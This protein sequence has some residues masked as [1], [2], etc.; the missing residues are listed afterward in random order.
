[1][2]KFLYLLLLFSFF[3]ELP[4]QGNFWTPIS[5]KEILSQRTNE[6]AYIPESFAAFQLDLTG[7]ATYLLDAP[8]EFSKGKES[9]V[10]HLP[11]PDGRLLAFKVYYSPVMQSELATKY[12]NIRSYKAYSLDDKYVNA[13]FDLGPNGL[14]A[15]IHGLNNIY[16]DPVQQDDIQNYIVYY[17][18]D[19]K[20]DISGYNLTCGLD[21][22]DILEE[23]LKEM[24]LFDSPELPGEKLEFRNTTEE[25]DSV[26]LFTYRLALSCTGEWGSAHGNTVES[27]LADMVTSVNRINQIYENEFSIRLLL[28]N[29]N[30]KLIW[31][32]K[33]TD[34]FP[35]GNVGYELLGINTVVLNNNVGPNSYDIGHVF[36]RSCTDVGGVASLGSVCSSNRK[37]SAVTCHYTNNLNYIVTNVMAHEMGH[38]FSASHTFNNCNGNESAGS[39]YEPGGGVTIMAYCGLCGG[40]NV[41]YDCLA[42]FHGHSVEQVNNF[43]KYGGGRQCAQILSTENTAPVAELEYTDGFTIPIGTPFMLTGSAFDCEGDE[44]SYSWEE[45][46]LGPQTQIGQP[47]EDSPIFT[48]HEPKDVPYRIFP[49]MSKIVN[50]FQNNAEILP[51][52]TRPLN[53]RFIVRDNSSN[54]GGTDW[55][56]VSFRADDDA[57]PFL[58]TYPAQF[59]TYSIGDEIEIKWDVANTNFPP[60]NC[61]RVH[62]S[63][64]T[65]AGYTYPFLLKYNTLNDGS[66][67]V[68][69]PNVESSLIRFKIEAA[70]NI[71]F[72]ISNN[73]SKIIKPEVPGYYIEASPL[74]QQVCL[75]D[76]IEIDI[77]TAGFNGYTDTLRFETGTGLPTGALVSFTPELA[78]PGDAVKMLI[79]LTSVNERDLYNLQILSISQNGDTLSRS[80]E[81]DVV[82]NDYSDLEIVQ[83]A[84]GANGQGQLVDLVW[85]KSQSADLYNVFL[86]DN[87]SFPEES[88]MTL[89]GTSDTIFTPSNTLDKSTLYYWKIEGINECGNRAASEILTFSTEAFSCKTYA[90]DEFPKDIRS[91]KT[92][93]FTINIPDDTNVADV[94]IISIIGDHDNF[95]DLDG[96]LIG[97]DSTIV[98]LFSAKCFQNGALVFNFGMDDESTQKFKCPP[99]LG[100]YYPSGKLSDLKGKNAKGDWVLEIFDRQSPKGGELAGFE[101]ELCANSV[102]SNPYLINNNSYLVAIGIP[103]DLPSSK[104]KVDDDDNLPDELIYTII[105]LPQL[106]SVLKNGES[107]Q[108][109]DQFSEEDIRNG[110][111]QLLSTQGQDGFEDA[112]VFTVI[113]GNGGWLDK[114]VFSFILD[115]EVY[116]EEIKLEEKLKIFPNPTMNTIEVNIY[117]PGD[118]ELRFFDMSGRLQIETVTTGFSGE[119][120]DLSSFQP[121][122]YYLKIF[123]QES[124]AIVKIIKQ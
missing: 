76:I 66:E 36:T 113:D 97:P 58:V 14:R 41:N 23:D 42:N 116:T 83:P 12:P 111:L 102:L 4:A 18:K 9:F 57:G 112:F 31:L 117:E 81:L 100:T 91:N 64:S 56:N 49:E 53:F 47:L 77:E 123:G 16:I 17:T 40:N 109:G 94:N 45:W 22:Y 46:D 104:L 50:N 80:V 48:A 37:G 73:Y 107:L 65:D 34:P 84:P 25:C 74:F 26:S 8:Q 30:D 86:S 120:I 122:V 51:E 70:D 39:D 95:Y 62:I 85:T 19:Y 10:V 119:K 61:K 54:G 32:D 69:L 13:R 6:D 82:T 108:V 90:S 99:Y 5:A 33:D 79:D 72:D 15:S 3:I 96:T 35:I 106:T 20:E 103:W 60:V 101:L 2:Q 28:I 105:E 55:A 89:L 87:P 93:S 92:T 88:T 115:E 118:F 52:Y 121:G 44:L 68:I 21:P 29:D 1:M 38:Q 98:N 59:E 110:S 75:P 67:H 43:I 11:A 114:T 124:S 27:A 71:F 63:M 7:M 24:D 78:L